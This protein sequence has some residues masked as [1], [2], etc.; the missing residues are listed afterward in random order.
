MPTLT[1]ST[2][3]PLPLTSAAGPGLPGSQPVPADPLA[4]LRDIHLPTEVTQLPI[5][6]GWWVLAGL[7]LIA[8]VV[9]YAAWRRHRDA[10]Q[11][12]RAALQLLQQIDVNGE[13]S[14]ASLQAIN[15]VLKRAALV[16]Y[17]QTHIAGFYG[18]AWSQFLRQSAPDLVQPAQVPDLLSTGLY[19]AP[20]AQ[21]ESLAI[22]L[23]YAKDWLRK[24][25]KES[26]LALMDRGSQEQ[27]SVEGLTPGSPAGDPETH[28][29]G[30][31][32]AAS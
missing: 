25:V 30:N 32:N 15:A 11:Y 21:T 6:P 19:A 29:Q 31:I 23:D 1:D 12:R 24:H 28:K 2:S 8:L 9:G 7:I 3:A 20:A 18:E 17:P 26:R 13:N 14:S 22:L 27:K 4:S 16:A 5:A 10:H